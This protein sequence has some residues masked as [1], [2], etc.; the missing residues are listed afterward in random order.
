MWTVTAS[1]TCAPAEIFFPCSIFLGR[2][3][4][5]FA[6]AQRHS[7]MTALE[8]L[9]QMQSY[10]QVSPARATVWFWLRHCSFIRHSAPDKGRW[11]TDNNE[12]RLSFRQRE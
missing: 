7:Y 10:S 1:S 12:L 2:G 4:N 3:E 6:V 5:Y 11:V 8:A 9:K